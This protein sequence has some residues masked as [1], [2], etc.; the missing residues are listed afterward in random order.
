M[1]LYSS[2]KKAAFL[3]KYVINILQAKI[4]DYSSTLLETIDID[5]KKIS[6]CKFVFFPDTK[7]EFVIGK[8]RCNA[9][10]TIFDNSYYVISKTFP[11]FPALGEQNCL[12]T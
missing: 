2:A 3:T 8:L 12:L 4:T 9:D 11:T 5:S 6:T 10:K 7:I 1:A